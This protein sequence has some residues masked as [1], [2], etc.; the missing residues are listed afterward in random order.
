MRPFCES[1]ELSFLSSN[2]SIVVRQVAL[3]Y[4]SFGS[5]LLHTNVSSSDSFHTWREEVSNHGT[6]RSF[7]SFPSSLG[8]P[9]ERRVRGAGDSRG[10][11]AG[12]THGQCAY[13]P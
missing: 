9:T 11:S 5:L 8:F 10:G 1:N 3:F 12:N 13:Q 6:Q 2:V 7:T 4:G